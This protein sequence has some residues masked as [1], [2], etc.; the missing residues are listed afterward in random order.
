[1]TVS[2][3]LHGRNPGAARPA[4]EAFLRELSE[5]SPEATE[6]AEPES[7]KIEPATVLGI[8]TLVLS[9]PGATLTGLQLQE[10]LRRRRLAARI[11]AL[12]ANLE[13]FDTEATL[14][15]DDGTALD[16]RRAQT[17][18]IIEALAK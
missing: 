17:D 6:A 11:E 15:L 12:K 10:M 4:A 2:L 16:L 1:M 14:N 3:D 13:A 7:T 18:Q 9:L 8:I 5:A